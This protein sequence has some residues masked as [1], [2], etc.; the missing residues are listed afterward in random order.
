MPHIAGLH[1]LERDRATRDGKSRL[2]V[3]R[4]LLAAALYDSLTYTVRGLHEAAP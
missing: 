2:D 4:S 1:L 3:Q